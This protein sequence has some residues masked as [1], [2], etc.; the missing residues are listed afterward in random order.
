LEQI[1]DH[2]E[3]AMGADKPAADDVVVVVGL[4][5]PVAYLRLLYHL[6]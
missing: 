1:V 3:R 4:G 6:T 2:L 5:Q